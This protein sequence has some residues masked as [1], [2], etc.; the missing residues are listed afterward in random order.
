MNKKHKKL[1]L[2]FRAPRHSI[3]TMDHFNLLKKEQEKKESKENMV[4][5]V[6]KEAPPLATSTTSASTKFICKE[7]LPCGYCKIL[8]QPCVKDAP[9]ST[10]YPYWPTCNPYYP[11]YNPYDTILTCNTATT[12][13]TE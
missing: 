8:K 5:E 11:I 10:T 12:T 2:P 3:R 7:K 1:T 6:T 4:Q 13:T 9:L